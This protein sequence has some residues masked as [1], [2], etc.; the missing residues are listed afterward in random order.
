[1]AH[2]VRLLPPGNLTMVPGRR[3]V[4]NGFLLHSRGLTPDSSGA[5]GNTTTTVGAPPHTR[6]GE[7]PSPQLAPD[8]SAYYPQVEFRSALEL[9]DWL[10]EHH[11]SSPGIWL[12]TW[13]KHRGP[14]L[15]YVE[16]V[17][18]LLCFGWIDSKGQRVDEDRTSLLACPRRPGSGWSRI[19]KG[20]LDLLREQGRIQ[21]AGHAAIDRAVADG[22]WTKL[23]EAGTLREPDD[24]HTALDAAPQ[25][26]EHWD[27]FPP[28]PDARS[29][30]GSSP[31]RLSR[32]ATSGSLAPSRRLRSG[33]A[34]T[35][36][37]NR[38]V[39][40]AGGSHQE[41]PGLS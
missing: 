18:E 20:H 31:P 16:M 26:R 33:G 34:P 11:D 21:P 1:M 15:P 41:R 22:S 39:N 2:H 4:G 37:G 13:K 8:V 36:G 9:R 7:H 32:P 28:R 12:V 27:G 17:R 5:H 3:L 23:D 35:S 30:S 6:C 14:Y 19:N 38:K 29:W 40:R 25:A 24:L 10:A